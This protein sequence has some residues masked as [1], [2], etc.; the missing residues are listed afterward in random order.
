VRADERD[1]VFAGGKA[2]RPGLLGGFFQD[3]GQVGP[4]Q[5]NRQ[6]GL[7]RPP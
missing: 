7:I 6:P 1:N 5:R 4:G 3:D 2:C